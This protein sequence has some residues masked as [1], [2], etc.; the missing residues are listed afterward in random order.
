MRLQITLKSGAQI[1]VDVTSLELT[2][3][4]LETPGAARSFTY[5]KAKW[6]HSRD[7]TARLVGVVPQ[8]IAAVVHLAD[9][10]KETP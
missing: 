3:Q 10:P 5:I 2:P 9:P 4:E 8:E 7:A 1:E 6:E